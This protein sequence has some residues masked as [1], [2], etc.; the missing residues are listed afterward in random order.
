[1]RNFFLLIN[2]D[3]ISISMILLRFYIIVLIILSQFSSNF[4]INLFF[5]FI[6]LN[7]SL[8]YSFSTNNIIIFYFF[9]WVIFNSNFYYYYSLRLSNRTNKSQNIYAILHTFCFFTLAFNHYYDYPEKLLQI[10]IFFNIEC[11]SLI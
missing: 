8:I 4:L 7:V 6:I 2:L 5:I 3:I 9:F 10:Y 11:K 1:M